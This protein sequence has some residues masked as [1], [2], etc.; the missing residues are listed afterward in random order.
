MSER[1]ILSVYTHTAWR[2]NK[3]PFFHF[4]TIF[5]DLKG[6]ERGDGS[7]QT[8][9]NIGQQIDAKWSCK[10]LTC[11]KSS[12]LEIKYHFTLFK[13]FPQEETHEAGFHLTRILNVPVK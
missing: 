2:L 9:K 7:V 4:Q 3:R 5:P 1:E 10:N 6:G 11:V 12:R 8:K 13:N